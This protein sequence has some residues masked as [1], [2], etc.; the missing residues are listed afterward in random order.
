MPSTY[1]PAH[2]FQPAHGTFKFQN[3][4]LIAETYKHFP[5]AAAYPLRRLRCPLPD[6]FSHHLP[7][8][9]LDTADQDALYLAV[10]HDDILHLPVLGVKHDF[11]VPVK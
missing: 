5:A 4:V 8:I 10:L 3:T 7:S 9:H 11:S 1:Y 2:L 6:H